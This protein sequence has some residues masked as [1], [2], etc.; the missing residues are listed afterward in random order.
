LIHRLP[1]SLRF[2]RAKAFV[3]WE[4]AKAFTADLAATLATISGELATVDPDAAIDR[5]VRFLSTA[6]RATWS[7]G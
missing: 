7:F 3:D 6:Y 2:P 1:W 4:K 5:L